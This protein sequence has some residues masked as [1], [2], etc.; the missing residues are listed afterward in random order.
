V[1]RPSS[2]SYCWGL[3]AWTPEVSEIQ[4]AQ[5]KVKI[6]FENADSSSRVELIPLEIKFEVRE[7]STAAA[8]ARKT[9]HTISRRVDY[10][11]IDTLDTSIRASEG[12]AMTAI[13]EVNKRVTNLAT[14]QRQETHE[15]YVRYGTL[16]TTTVR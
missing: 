16:R 5:K 7:S 4:V 11:F 13:E 1:P 2:Q 6:A 8:A 14:T 12:R 15:L 9:G 3:P 10:R